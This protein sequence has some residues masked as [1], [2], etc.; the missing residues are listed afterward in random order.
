MALQCSITA[1]GG[2]LVTNAYMRIE[3]ILIK[4]DR[5]TGKYWMTIVLRNYKNAAEASK[6]SP[7]AIPC[8]EVDQEKCG[9]DLAGAS[10]LSQAYTYL[11]TLPLFSAAVDV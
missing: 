5:L 9:Y 2:V 11:K 8:P 6:I 1:L 3:S 10:A 7:V 4:K